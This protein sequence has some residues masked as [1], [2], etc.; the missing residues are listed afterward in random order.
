MFISTTSFIECNIVISRIK[1][2]VLITSDMMN[3]TFFTSSTWGQSKMMDWL[4]FAD[5]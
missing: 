3:Q 2:E 4:Q 5:F 1:S